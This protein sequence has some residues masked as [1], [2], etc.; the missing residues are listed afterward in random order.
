[1]RVDEIK[2]AQATGL[3]ISIARLY[4]APVAEIKANEEHKITRAEDPFILKVVLASSLIF[5][6]VSIT[7]SYDILADVLFVKECFSNNEQR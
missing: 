4:T 6:V 3:E 1:M 2:E 7:A 5:I